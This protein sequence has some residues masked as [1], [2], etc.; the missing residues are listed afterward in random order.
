M[1]VPSSWHRNKGQPPVFYPLSENDPCPP[2]QI[3]ADDVNKASVYVRLRSGRKPLRSWPVIGRPTPTR[4]TLTGDPF[5]ITH[6][7]RA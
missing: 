3:H 6:W 7:R 1:T 2:D 4:W 5:D